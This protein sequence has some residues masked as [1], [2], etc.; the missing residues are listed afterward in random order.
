MQRAWP[1]SYTPPNT[2]RAIAHQACTPGRDRALW[3]AQAALR[4]PF[5]QSRQ[6]STATLVRADSTAQP[7]WSEQQHGL[8]CHSAGPLLSQCWASAVTVLG[9]CCHS[10]CCY[11]SFCC[12]STVHLLARPL[13]SKHCARAITASAVK[14]LCT[15]YHGLC[16]LSTVHLLSRPLRSQRT[17]ANSLAISVCS[18]VCSAGSLRALPGWHTQRYRLCSSAS[19]ILQ[20]ACVCVHTCVYVPECVQ[21]FVCL[22]ALLCARVCTHVCSFLSVCMCLCVCVRFCVRVCAYMCVHVFAH[23]CVCTC[24]CACALA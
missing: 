17:W 23:M 20:S 4:S 22:S 5:G 6:H 8:C 3:S 24:T 12:Q 16:C 14:A 19:A 15:C 11:V 21:A 7:L 2:A 9:T 1:S 10:P 18:A 13:R